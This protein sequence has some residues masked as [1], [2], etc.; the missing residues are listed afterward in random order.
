MLD[1]S[2][3]PNLD[4]EKCCPPNVFKKLKTDREVVNFNSAS[5]HKM[6]NFVLVKPSA[7]IGTYIGHSF[8]YAAWEQSCFWDALTSKIMSI[9]SSPRLEFSS[10]AT[11][12]RFQ[13]FDAKPRDRQSLNCTRALYSTAVQRPTSTASEYPGELLIRHATNI[14][15][16]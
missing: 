7:T 9:S 14:S 16:I 10:Y 8:S 5:N 13:S 12:I 15:W 11:V 1:T 4:R 3:G 2:A 6:N